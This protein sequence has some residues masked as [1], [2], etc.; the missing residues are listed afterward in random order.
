MP[1]SP[2]QVQPSKSDRVRE[3]TAIRRA[4]LKNGYVP[5]ANVD[6]L[7]ALE[8]WP[9]MKV[10]AAKIDEWAD[11]FRY[12]ATGVR[13]DGRLVVVDFDINDNDVLD[14]IWGR[15]DEGLANKLTLA[16]TRFGGGVKMAVFLR[17][18][19]GEPVFGRMVSQSYSPPGVDT[20]QKVEIFGSGAARQFGAFGPHSHDGDGAVKTWYRWADDV[21]LVD[22]PLDGLGEVTRDELLAICDAASAAMPAAGWE[23]EVKTRSGLVEEGVSFSLTD[24]M[25]FET[26]DY[27]VLSLGELEAVCGGVGEGVRLS[28]SWKEGAAAVNTSRCIARLNEADGRL[29]I[30]ESADCRLYRPAELNVHNVVERLSK[31]VRE[32]A[33]KGESG[34][35][36]GD[37]A[38][39]VVDRWSALMASAAEKGSA[40]DDLSGAEKEEEAEKAE[41]DVAAGR[42]YV[43][44]FLLGRYAYWAAGAGYVVD[45]DGGIQD[46]MT[47]TSFRNL[48]APMNWTEKSKSGRKNAA[49]VEI[50]PADIWLKHADRREVK[51]YRFMPDSRD[52][53]AVRDDRAYVNTW[54]RPVWWD[55]DVAVDAGA[56][57][58]FARFMEHLVPD[59]REREWVLMWLAAKTQKPWLPNCG[60]IMVA[61]LQGTGRGTLFDMLR[62]VFGRRHVKNATAMQ[63]FGDGS[64]AQYTDWI[65]QSLIVTCDE[66]LA[67][68]DAGG[69]MAWKRREV[70]EKLKGLVDPRPRSMP[71]VRKG[72]PNDEAEVF[73]SFLLAT[74]N[75][76]ALPLSPDDRRIA[77]VT[78]TSVPLVEVPEVLEILEPWRTDVGFSDTFAASVFGWLKARPV[79]WAEV[80][81]SP[82]WMSGRE[83]MLA[84]NETDLEGVVQNVLAGVEGDYILAQ[85]LRERVGRSLEANGLLEETKGWWAKTQD[86]LSRVNRCGWRK[87]DGRQRYASD[88]VTANTSVVFYRERLP[89]VG[90]PSPEEVWKKT[91]LADR[92]KL[93]EGG[94]EIGSTK[95]KL[96]ARMRESGVTG[97]INND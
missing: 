76:N 94:S 36:G 44:Q 57:E 4:L 67:G 48:F 46:V 29:Q 79:V 18:A 22:V 45:L 81:E 60:V 14:D 42:E 88:K 59:A 28:A 68:D 87:M 66:V 26:R 86:M 49:E 7:C 82:R 51:G 80:R 54:E 11:Q 77:V 19:E 35:D 15:L 32:K 84:A 97:V 31:K 96:A 63:M 24:A 62:G 3:Q 70:Y 21:S 53:V 56:V 40:F 25:K 9:G 72:V 13:V 30:W 8:G 95:S 34:G 5:L 23:Y 16:P 33:D 91:A 41:A 71:I 37:G 73:A 55:Q 17:L 38:V 93:W 43:V 61:E 10:D 75:I 2:D 58:V 1:H 85:H 50:S 74:N 83:R 69:T 78:N 89:V 92:E 20:T 47:M 52:K 64:Q 90:R 65:E 39:E 6:K 12:T 27:G